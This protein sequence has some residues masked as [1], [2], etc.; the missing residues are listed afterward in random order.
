VKLAVDIER[1]VIDDGALV[2]DRAER[3][4]P[5]VEAELERRLRHEPLASTPDARER[6][7]VQPLAAVPNSDEEL[8][9]ELAA[10]IV[11]SLGG[12][13]S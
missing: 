2:A 12:G 4:G 6:V 13:A 10:R 11:E 5:L 9:R 7:R 1:I 3:I 8:A